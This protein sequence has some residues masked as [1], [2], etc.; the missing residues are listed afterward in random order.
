[1][2]ILDGSKQKTVKITLNRK[3]KVLSDYVPKQ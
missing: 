1:M 2:H 3:K